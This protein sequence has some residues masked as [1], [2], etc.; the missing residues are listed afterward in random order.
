MNKNSEL[1]LDS[2]LLDLPDRLELIN[3]FLAGCGAMYD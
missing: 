3:L 1:I 2:K